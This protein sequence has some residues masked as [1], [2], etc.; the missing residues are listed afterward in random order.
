MIF[1]TNRLIVGL[2]AC[3]LLTGCHRKPES[4]PIPENAAVYCRFENLQQSWDSLAGR[5]FFQRSSGW[6]LWNEPWMK[7]AM[8]PL[9]KLRSDFEKD[10]GIPLNKNTIMMLFGQRVDLVILP[11]NPLPDFLLVSELGNSSAA[12]KLL[13]RTMETLEKDRVTV[14]EF[15]KT[16]ITV[17]QQMTPV[18]PGMPAVSEIAYCFVD[19]RLLAAT[20]RSVLQQQLALR[21]DPD[22]TLR[23]NADFLQMM[24]VLGSPAN[25]IYV[26]P[27]H[28]LSM[29]P[30]GDDNADTNLK[31]PVN[32][33]AW[34]AG[35]T[36][37]DTG[38][39][40]VTAMKPSGQDIERWNTIYR[41]PAAVERAGKWLASG[42]IAGSAAGIDIPGLMEHQ[43]S[44]LEALDD[45]D[46]GNLW[47]KSTA[48][49]QDFTGLDI[50][51]E[52]SR[53]G[54][55]GMFFTLENIRMVSLIPIPDLAFG[56]H[57]RDRG[58][59]EDFVKALERQVETKA[60]PDTLRFERESISKDLFYH[61]VPIPLLP[62]FQPGYALAGDFLV[63]GTSS[64]TVSMSYQASSGE[65]SSILENSS[66]KPLVSE[67]S[68]NLVG[69]QAFDPTR[70]AG[71]ARTALDAAAMFIVAAD[72][73][74]EVYREIL[75]TLD[76]IPLVAFRLTVE[77]NIV[78]YSGIVEIR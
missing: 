69:Y 19:D 48:A 49:L 72:Q 12:L 52:F 31:S 35:L 67:N 56:I 34:A 53:W 39:K 3:I 46:G 65:I 41:N 47:T 50:P 37:A 58:A 36:V 30:D 16:R 23:N 38:L 60:G 32:A 64:K 14:Y 1:R 55:N 40:S 21:S 59:A 27:G 71:S 7:D 75:D 42:L 73:K 9:L 63:F 61:Y 5:E 51:G 43:K 45:S 20:D 18:T 29:V 11:D 4:E 62:G 66:L 26:Q 6:Q 8:A 68:E 15:E 25:M 10:T 33:D 76:M 28:L 24:N 13:S 57:V 54:G 78:V 44:I 74:P 17:V 2:L 77:N 70:F 22:K